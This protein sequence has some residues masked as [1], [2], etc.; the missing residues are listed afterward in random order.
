VL[1]TL[2]FVVKA[3]E[4]RSLIHALDEL[5][6]EVDSSEEQTHLDVLLNEKI[7][8]LMSRAVFDWEL[9]AIESRF[10]SSYAELKRLSDLLYVSRPDLKSEHYVP[11]SGFSE[12]LSNL[13]LENAGLA[14]KLPA[15]RSQ[16]QSLLRSHHLRITKLRMRSILDLIKMYETR[17]FTQSAIGQIQKELDR[18]LLE[19]A[20]FMQLD[21]QRK[22]MLDEI[23]LLEFAI[24]ELSRQAYP[25]PVDDVCLGFT[26]S[27]WIDTLSKFQS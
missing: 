2:L 21:G 13:R 24:R 25:K 15:L 20:E 23:H 27:L 1:L 17:N 14:E 7:R 12:I 16:K 5:A 4:S 10:R 9:H 26:T 22:S 6:K 18:R 3:Q 19:L 11:E 8:P